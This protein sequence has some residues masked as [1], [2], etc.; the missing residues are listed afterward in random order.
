MIPIAAPSHGHLT[1]WLGKAGANGGATGRV[2]LKAMRGNG[3]T[4]AR[5]VCVWFMK[6]LFD[7]QPDSSVSEEVGGVTPI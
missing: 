1:D 6:W 2:M 5:Q 4:S 3:L 7:S